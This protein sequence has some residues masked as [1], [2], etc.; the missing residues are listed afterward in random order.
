MQVELQQAFLAEEKVLMIDYW[1]F[2][3]DS[4][5]FVAVETIW[6]SN[7]VETCLGWRKNRMDAEPEQTNLEEKNRASSGLLRLC[8]VLNVV[9]VAS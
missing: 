9:Q 4:L 1:T 6:Y 7:H 2:F 3:E 8:C 5:L